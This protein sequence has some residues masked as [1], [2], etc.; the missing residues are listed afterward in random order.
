MSTITSED[1]AAAT[2]NFLKNGGSITRLAEDVKQSGKV[3]VN[4]PAMPVVRSKS[5]HKLTAL[6]AFER[7]EKFNL[8]RGVKI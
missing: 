8:F 3:K 7:A 6:E 2:K 1:V 5:R 4:A